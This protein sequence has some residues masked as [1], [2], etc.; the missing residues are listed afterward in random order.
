MSEPRKILIFD[1]TL[2]DGEQSPGC[3]MNLAE[4]LEVARMLEA[5]RVDVIEAGFPVASPGDFE[6]VQAV[7]EEIRGCTVAGLARAVDKDIERAAEAVAKSE[8]RRI[9]VFCATSEIHR[10]HKLKRAKDEIIRMS[11][12]GV[13]QA[14]GYTDDVEFSPEDASRTEPEFLAEVVTAVI[15]AGATTVNIPDTVGYAMPRQFGDLIRYLSRHVSNIDRAVISVHCHND[16]GLAVANSLAAVSAG[17]GQIECTI[18]GLGERAGNAA[19]EEIVMAMK[20]RRDFLNADTNIDTRKIYPASRMVAAITGVHVQR[21]KAIVGDYVQPSNGTLAIE[22]GG[23]VAGTEYDKVVVVGTAKIAG[24]LDLSLIS[25]FMPNYNDEFEILTA[26]SAIGRF[27]LITG[28]AITPTLYLATVYNPDNIKI[29][30]AIP[31]DANFDV[32]VDDSDLNFL[33]TGWGTGD[34]WR[35]GDFNGSGSVNDSDLNL[36]LSNWTY[37]PSAS[38]VPEP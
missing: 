38:A 35:E 17:A 11:V 24:R 12:D 20:T 6:A 26:G 1:T 31:G 33:L 23:L 10:T 4:K 22:I 37:P 7:A 9:H 28:M 3:S 5:L 16:L 15:E 2:R 34:E 32:R 29:V 13:R 27:D 30:A 18:N 19:L 25:G 8:R 36:L 21:N 14:K